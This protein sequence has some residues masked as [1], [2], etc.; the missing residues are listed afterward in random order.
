MDVE[1]WCRVADKLTNVCVCVY[2]LG[3]CCYCRCTSMCWH[4]RMAEC[5][6]VNIYAYSLH[7]ASMIVDATFSALHCIV[8][9]IHDYIYSH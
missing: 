1:I 8:L 2:V 6:Y 5:V 9:V 3:V 4:M 7:E